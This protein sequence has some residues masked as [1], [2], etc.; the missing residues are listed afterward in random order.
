MPFA[1]LLAFP[2]SVMA[3]DNSIVAFGHKVELI[4]PKAAEGRVEVDGRSIHQNWSLSL[5]EVALVGGVPVLLGSSG[6]GGNSCEATPFVISFPDGKTPRFDGPVDTCWIVTH[7]IASDRIT[8]S[9]PAMPDADGEKW[10]W[11]PADGLKSDGKVKFVPSAEKGWSDLRDRSL[12]HP[13]GLFDYGPVATRI[14]QLLGDRKAQFLTAMNGPGIGRY[15][16][17]W[18]IGTA[19]QRHNCSYT[20]SGSIVALDIPGRRLFLAWKPDGKKIEVRPAVAEWPSEARRSLATWAKEF[21][22]SRPNK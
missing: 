16:G 14:D 7:K 10:T 20:G 21:E 1:I 17:D 6:N 12:N 2:T 13:M 18:F 15:E 9:T 8:F 11:T 5:D 3:S 19:C 4:R 22:I